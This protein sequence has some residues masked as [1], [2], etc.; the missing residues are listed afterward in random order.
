MELSQ[1]KSYLSSQNK[2]EENARDQRSLP[3]DSSNKSSTQNERL[4]NSKSTNSI[5]HQQRSESPA[6]APNRSP[7]DQPRTSLQS[8]KH[9]PAQD[10]DRE[11]LRSSAKVHHSRGDLRRSEINQ[12]EEYQIQSLLE[13]ISLLEKE[14]ELKV[15][16][17]QQ[18]LDQIV[19]HRR[20]MLESQAHIEKQKLQILELQ[21]ILQ[22]VHQKDSLSSIEELTA[23][24]NENLQLRGVLQIK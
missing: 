3:S 13:K 14:N 16:E 8:N 17:K 5:P 22:T 23:Q 4:G 21:S 1:T 24:K 10:S 6:F 20:V 12:I 19:E 18:F 11:L 9:V 15:L 7:I 2:L